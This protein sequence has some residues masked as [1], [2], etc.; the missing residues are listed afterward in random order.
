M[1]KGMCCSCPSSS[2]SWL[3]P[4]TMS[5]TGLEFSLRNHSGSTGVEAYSAESKGPRPA[6][7]LFN[8]QAIIVFFPALVEPLLRPKLG[9]VPGFPAALRHVDHSSRAQNATA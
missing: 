3:D 9:L 8:L 5:V 1:T 6:K 4:Y 7:A 2:I